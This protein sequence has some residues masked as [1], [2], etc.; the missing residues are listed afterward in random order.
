MRSAYVLDG[1]FRVTDDGDVFRVKDGT[2][3]PAQAGRAGTSAGRR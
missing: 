1:R 3:R 2:E